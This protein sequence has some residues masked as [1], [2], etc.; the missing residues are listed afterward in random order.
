MS[1]GDKL[2]KIE[3]SIQVSRNSDDGLLENILLDISLDELLN[4]V[5]AKEDDPELFDGYMLDEN[6][7]EK[8]NN[9]SERQIQ[10][11]FKS[12]WY[13]LVCLGIYDWQT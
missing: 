13:V 2:I 7:I 10:P 9:F 4:I 1:L 6:Q 11:D 8:L 12:Y 5:T 3:R